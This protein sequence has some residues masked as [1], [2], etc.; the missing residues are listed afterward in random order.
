ME[1]PTVL[2]E[3]VVM[4]GQILHS[5][6]FEGIDHA[7]FFVVIGVSENAIAGF[8]YINSEINRHI[9][10][11]PEQ[12]QMQYPLYAKDYNFLAHDSYICATNVVELPKADIVRSIENKHTKV[13]DTLKPE[14]L[15]VLLDKLRSSKLFS[16]ITK[17]RYFQSANPD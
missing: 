5:D 9:N 1:L 14:H 4:R 3:K 12:L 8:F 17:K 15:K 2:I 16:A 10:T 7:K 13:V 11:K 6:I